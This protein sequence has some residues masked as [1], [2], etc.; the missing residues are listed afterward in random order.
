MA[1]FSVDSV[2]EVRHTPGQHTAV[3]RAGNGDIL[4]MYGD[5][6]DQVESQ[7]G[8]T[9]RSWSLP[10]ARCSSRPMGSPA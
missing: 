5:F 6:T 3:T 7:T 2:A 9:A 1:S 8:P 4:A 10:T